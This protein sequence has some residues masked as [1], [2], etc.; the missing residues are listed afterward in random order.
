VIEIKITGIILLIANVAFSWKGLTDKAFFD[1]NKFEVGKILHQ[2]E[3]LRILTSGFLH[4]SWIHLLFNM[5]GLYFFSGLL[6]LTLGPG[7]FVLLYF[8]GLIGGDLFSLFLH[9]NHHDY[10]AVGASGAIC[11]LVFASIAL[12]PGLEMSLFFIPIFIPGWL[13][14]LIYV[15]ISIY[16]IRSQRDNI[17]HDAHLGGALAGMLTAIAMQPGIFAQNYVTI[18]I[19]T[20]PTLIFIYLIVT[21]PQI[22]L[23]DNQFFK[24]QKRYFNI[25]EKYNEQ[26]SNKQ[27]ELN[28][29]LDKISQK[30]I[31]SL[32]QKEKQRLDSLSR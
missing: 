11:G 19:I 18:L 16:G 29:L 10:S 27:K 4:V 17:G 12:F 14:G 28:F 23:I 22:L 32:T 30:G 31:G 3:Y 1:R 26:K 8:S 2:K 15:G 25:D 5:I 20:V 24:S 9:R 21:R 6:E 13:Y 7:L